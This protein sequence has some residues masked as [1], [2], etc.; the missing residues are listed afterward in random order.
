MRVLTITTLYPNA[1]QPSHGI[2]VENRIRHLVGT[3]I[4]DLQVI[5]PVPWFPLSN[6]VFG[7]YARYARAPRAEERH[8]I[9]IRHPRFLAIPKIGMMAAPLL[10]G[11][12]LLRDVRI[13]MHAG[14]TFDVIDAHYFYPDGVAAAWLGRR[15]GIPVAITARGTDLNYFVQRHPSVRQMIRRAAQKA[16]GLIVVCEALKNVLI[17]LGI[18][19]SRI[20][21]LRNGVDLQLFRP[22]DRT[23]VR[24]ALSL[25]RPTLLSIG[26]LIPRKGHDVVIGALAHLPGVELL[27]AGEGPERRRLEMLARAL[28]V[29]DR[30]RFLGHVPHEDLARVYGAAD[31][32]ILA[33]SR[34]GWANVL[35]EAMACGTP[36]V[37]SDVW[38]TPEVVNATAAGILV[39]ERTPE[40]FSNAIR[41][42]FGNPPPR[43][44]TRSHAEMFSWD[45]TTQGQLDLFRAIIAHR[46]DMH[47]FAPAP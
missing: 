38:G 10:L 34:E 2:F 3:G 44:A 33:S 9:P 22:L 1:A 42:L 30:V 14:A 7:R 37:A 29:A 20:Q 40:A 8:G 6:V 41:R 32:L 13:L 46:R 27:I 16:D 11:A 24:Q 4:I 15:L 23:Q 17:D 12:A 47:A 39:R 43:S 19:R 25:S 31:A 5:A 28:C 36:V 18:P 26:Q 45:T 21:V 35:L